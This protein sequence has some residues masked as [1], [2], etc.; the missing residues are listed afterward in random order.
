MMFTS[1]KPKHRLWLRMR[2]TLFATALLAF[3]SAAHATLFDRGLDLVYDDALNITWTRSA[4]L[5]G[6]S[7]LTWT[8]A[9][10]W[11]ANLVYAGYDDWRLPYASVSAGV[12]PFTSSGPF[13]CTGAGG[14]DEVSCRDSEVSYMFFY[15]LDGNIGDLKTGNQTAM[16]GEQLTGIQ[17][18][19]WSGTAFDSN[20]AW[21]LNFA[22]GNQGIFSKDT[23]SSAWAVREGD[24]AAT[25]EP[26]SLALLGLGLA[27]LGF[28]RRKKS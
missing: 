19:Y 4:N 12:G 2:T 24:V 22:F 10:D 17:P 5:P 1:Q 26:A 11:A 3:G 6:S 9:N 23:L 8:Q 7:G 13:P 20:I 18:V 28:S 16:G 14:A 25:P 21:N 15:N 27:G